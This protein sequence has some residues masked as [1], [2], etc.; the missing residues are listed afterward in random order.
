MYMFRVL[1]TSNG[2]PISAIAIA[3]SGRDQFFYKEQSTRKTLKRHPAWHWPCAKMDA[4]TIEIHLRSPFGNACETLEDET[5]MKGITGECHAKD[6]N[7]TN[8]RFQ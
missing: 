5:I 4:E 8:A 1:A 6:I 2:A 3:I 7:S